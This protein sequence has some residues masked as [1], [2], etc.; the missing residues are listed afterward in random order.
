MFRLYQ[1]VTVSFPLWK[2]LE[3]PA[4]LVRSPPAR[5]NSF[6]RRAVR[7]S[8]R[9]TETAGRLNVNVKLD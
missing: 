5:S 9:K 8:I 3:L 7:A 2:A 4:A 1:R 6:N